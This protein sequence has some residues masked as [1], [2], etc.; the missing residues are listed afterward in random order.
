VLASA[1]E[2]TDSLPPLKYLDGLVYLCKPTESLEVAA[3][4]DGIFKFLI[5]QRV[6]M[7]VKV[8]HRIEGQNLKAHPTEDVGCANKRVF[9]GRE[10]T[11]VSW[12][13]RRGYPKFW[14]YPPSPS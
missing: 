6:K 1:R 14:Y 2:H 9:R 7:Q 5:G 8:V 13:V 10:H 12:V 3:L 11:S 4:R